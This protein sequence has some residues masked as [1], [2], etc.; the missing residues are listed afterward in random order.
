MPYG[1]LKGGL[2]R[3][4]PALLP[5]GIPQEGPEPEKKSRLP[6]LW[7]LIYI[8]HHG[9]AVLPLQLLE[10]GAIYGSPGAAGKGR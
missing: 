1:P 2:H 4:V 6:L 5:S 3:A 7:R 9:Y 8:K 10:P